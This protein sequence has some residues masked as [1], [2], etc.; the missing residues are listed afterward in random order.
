MALLQNPKSCKIR[1]ASI[2]VDADLYIFSKVD[3]NIHPYIKCKKQRP[4]KFIN[5]KL[6]KT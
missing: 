3:E 6:D 1:A 2:G 4:K 5:F